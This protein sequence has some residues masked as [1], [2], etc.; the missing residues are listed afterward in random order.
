MLVVSRGIDFKQWSP[1]CWWLATIF[2]EENHQKRPN[3]QIELH[4]IESE[5]DE[6]TECIAMGTTEWKSEHSVR[7][8][9][10]G[11][12]ALKVCRAVTRCRAQ[13]PKDVSCN[14]KAKDATVR[15][16]NLHKHECVL[17]RETMES[18]RVG[19]GKNWSY[20]SRVCER[21]TGSWSLCL[22]LYASNQ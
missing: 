5:R 19:E 22:T 12:N 20:Y 21:M 11:N 13:I 15:L 3:K 8:T 6:W 18:D 1:L 17:D 2:D 16:N 14:S 7:S 10:R 4:L 9:Y